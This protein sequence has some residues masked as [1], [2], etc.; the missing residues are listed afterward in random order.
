MTMK[1]LISSTRAEALRLRKWPAFWIILGT[2]ILLNLTFSYLF[3]Y[4]AYTSGESGRMSNGLP[5]DVLLQQMLPAAVPG[6]FT[7]GMAMFGGALMLVLGA[8]ATG[9]GFGWGTWKTVFTQGPS[10]INVVGGVLV[11][12]LVVVLALVL[13]AFAVDIGVAS[14]IGA[15]QGQS[16]ALPSL[17]QSALGVLTGVV[18]LGMWTLAGALI[19]ALARGPAL[20]VGLGLVWVLVVEN[21]LRGV[22]GIFAPIAV[23]T[24]H[25]PGT[26]AGSLAGAMRTVGAGTPGVLDILSRT[27]ALLVLAIYIALFVAGTVY[28]MRRRD[29]V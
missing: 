3:N 26:A 4:L 23:L 11:S 19:G 10:R 13:T 29:L 7:Q 20:A 6:V 9:S 12:L 8:L 17:R 27:E 21:L 24:D 15:T 1:D 22:A 18:I 14:L 28:S 25:L 2:W 5:R 16:L